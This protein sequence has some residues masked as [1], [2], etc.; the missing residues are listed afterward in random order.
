MVESIKELRLLCQDA[1]RRGDMSL[2]YRFNKKYSIYFTKL[3]LYTPISANQTTF[4]DIII[5]LVIF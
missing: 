1:E 3:L 5:E 2:T 4:I